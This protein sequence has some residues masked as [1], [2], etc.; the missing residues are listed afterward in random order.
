MYYSKESRAFSENMPTEIGRA[1][2]P[3][4]ILEVSCS[5]KIEALYTQ[6][7][8]SFFLLNRQSP[9]PYPVGAICIIAAE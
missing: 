7:K 2:G 1:V 6:V 9:D 5:D 4:F 8:L 3:F